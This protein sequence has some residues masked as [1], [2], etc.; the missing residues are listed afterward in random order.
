[1]RTK[2]NQNSF[3]MSKKYKKDLKKDKKKIKEIIGGGSEEEIGLKLSDLTYNDQ[4]IIPSIH[5][6]WNISKNDYCKFEDL[7]DSC[8]FTLSQLR[9]DINVLKY[10]NFKKNGYF[11][12]LGGTNGINWSNTYLLEKNIIGMVYL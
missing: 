10:L 6:V 9:Q 12:E 11:I 5:T 4:I 3:K 7:T 1:M 2:K 8:S